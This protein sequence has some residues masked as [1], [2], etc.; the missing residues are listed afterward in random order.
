M[1]TEQSTLNALYA[2]RALARECHHEDTDWAR[3]VFATIEA[4]L[5]RID[6]AGLAVVKAES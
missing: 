4:E 6:P 1:A 3:E 2:G 5:E